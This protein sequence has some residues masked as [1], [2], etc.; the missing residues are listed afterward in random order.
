MQPD[1]AFYHKELGEFLLPYDAVRNSP[2][3]ERALLSFLDST[4]AAGATL[5]G[6]DRAALERPGSAPSGR[7]E[8]GRGVASA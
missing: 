2:A 3:P 4:Y 1:A 6:W 8:Q 5:A 7:P